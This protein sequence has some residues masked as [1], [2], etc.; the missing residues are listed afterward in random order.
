VPGT[1]KLLCW[2]QGDD[3]DQAFPL[4]VVGSKTVSYLRE[5]IKEKRPAFDRV[6]ADALILWKVSSSHL[7]EL[8]PL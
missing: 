6:S 5:V 3:H 7:R 4:N 2:V 1:L 8:T